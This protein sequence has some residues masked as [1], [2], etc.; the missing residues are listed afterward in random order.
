MTVKE[1]KKWLE[2]IPDDAEVYVQ[3]TEEGGLLYVD[4]DLLYYDKSDNTVV[5]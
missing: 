1:L 4:K 2:D 5:L 3:D